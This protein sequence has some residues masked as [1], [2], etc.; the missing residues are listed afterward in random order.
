[1]K[2]VPNSGNVWVTIGVMVGSYLIEKI[3]DYVF[4]EIK[5]A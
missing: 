3:I 2:N 1:M 5:K 4:D